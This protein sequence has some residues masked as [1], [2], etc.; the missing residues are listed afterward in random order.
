MTAY[1]TI[2]FTVIIIYI[3]TLSVF[4]SVIILLPVSLCIGIIVISAIITSV[5]YYC[6][7][8]SSLLPYIMITLL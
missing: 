1:I 2:V 3:Y 6:C 7:L 4:Y 8:G 5:V